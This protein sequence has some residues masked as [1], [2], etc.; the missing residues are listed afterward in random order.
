[1]AP[2]ADA[3]YLEPPMNPGAG[4]RVRVVY[5]EP[6]FQ[7]RNPHCPAEYTSLIELP[8]ASSR[9]AAVREALARWDHDAHHSGVGWRRVIKSVTVES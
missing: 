7:L 1:M 3:T 8:H 6:G 5:S 2:P 4:Y 9:A